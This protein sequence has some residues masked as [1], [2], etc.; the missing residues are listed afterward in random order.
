MNSNI[1]NFYLEAN[2]LKNVIRTGWKE[3]GIPE[4]KIESV[5]D[6]ICGTMILALSIIEAK[7]LSLNTDKVFKMIIVSELYKAVANKEESIISSSKKEDAKILTE[8]IVNKL[9]DNSLL[10]IYDE[11][12]AM[13]SEESKFTYKVS[14][15]ESDIQAKIYEKNGYFTIENAKS[16]IENYP[17][18]IKSQLVEIGKASDGWITYDR[19]YY[20]DE[21]FMSLSKDIQEL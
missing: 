2:N 9:G 13:E 20:D 14:K 1:I 17:E 21:L 6:H 12:K 3:V 4:D 8:S 15:L 5:S 7:N 18:D 10:S 19:K 16:D 11:Y